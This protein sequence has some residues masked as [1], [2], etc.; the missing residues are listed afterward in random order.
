M[1]RAVGA[2][3]RDPVLPALLEPLG[4]P[5]PRKEPGLLRGELIARHR[6][7]SWLG[8]FALDPRVLPF[9][10]CLLLRNG[11][12]PARTSD[13]LFRRRPFPLRVRR[14]T[15]LDRSPIDWTPR[16]LGARE[17]P[18]SQRITCGKA[19]LEAFI[20][21][22]VEMPL[23]IALRPALAELLDS[24]ARPQRNS[25][26][27]L[28]RTVL[29]FGCRARRFKLACNARS[30]SLLTSSRSNHLASD[31]PRPNFRRRT[32]TAE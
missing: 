25:Y 6:R 11:C 22:G 2:H 28:S 30:T 8:F 24:S 23:L 18:H 14:W 21:K 16:R 7:P 10:L 3:G 20:D 32:T 31:R 4:R 9:C 5:F 27:D 1:R 15:Q 13:F 26:F 12:R 17:R 29:R 19:F